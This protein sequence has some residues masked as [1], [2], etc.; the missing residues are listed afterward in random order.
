MIGDSV[1]APW[2]PFSSLFVQDPL[3]RYSLYPLGHVSNQEKRKLDRVYYPRTGEMLAESYDF[4]V[5]RDA[6]VTH[7]TPRQFKDLEHVF[8]EE[9]MGSVAV[10]SLSW[11]VAWQP[12][13]LIELSP[14]SEYEFRFTIPWRVRIRRSADIFLPFLELGIEKA[15]GEEYGLMKPKPGARVWADM[16]P[17]DQPWLVSWRPGGG[18]PGMRWAFA[19]KFDPS[20]W[21]T[22]PGAKQDNPY[23]I[24]FATNLILHS[25]NRPLISDIHAIRY[26]RNLFSTLRSQKLLVLSM[27]SWAENFGANVLPISE[28]L[29]HIEEQSEDA[30]D[31]YLEQDYD[32]ATEFLALLDDVVTDISEQARRLKDQALF[33]VFV[34]EWLAV[35]SVSILAGLVL[36]TL[37]VKRRLYRPARETRLTRE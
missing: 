11:N 36:W 6:R 3:F 20:W 32:S 14:I 24:D 1:T 28:R 17:Q 35:T 21:G 23:A 31:S 5:F 15:V 30:V 27:L 25:L 33:W 8:R 34:S 19:D 10:H 9:G 13:V 4:M 37:M 22:A 29:S 12:T 7:F 26:A 16:V 18:N 2:N